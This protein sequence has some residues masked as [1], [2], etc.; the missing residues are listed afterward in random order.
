MILFIVTAM[1]IRISN[2][3]IIILLVVHFIQ[4]YRRNW[5]EYNKNMSSDRTPVLQK[6]LISCQEKSNDKKWCYDTRQTNQ[7]LS[8]E[9]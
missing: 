2:N 1:E 6:Y 9:I 4:H 5:K 3:T 8:L 7:S